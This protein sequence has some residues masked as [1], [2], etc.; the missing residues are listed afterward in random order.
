MARSTTSKNVKTVVDNESAA[1]SGATAMG[2]V[3]NTEETTENVDEKVAPSG[4]IAMDEKK[5]GKLA[6]SKETP[7]NNAG[8]ADTAAAVNNLNGL[9]F[10]VEADG[11]VE[12]T[13]KERAGTSVYGT[14]GEL[15]HF[16]ANGVTKVCVEEALHFHKMPG[17]AFK[18]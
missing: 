14:T 5:N 8:Q 7:I 4:T 11:L 9:P 16:D 10:V 1:P 2:E 13:A 17:F 3:V 15:V 6:L 18:K 12:V